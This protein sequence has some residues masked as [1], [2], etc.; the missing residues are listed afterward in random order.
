MRCLGVCV[1]VC[2]LVAAATAGRTQEPNEN[3]CHEQPNTAAINA[4]LAQVYADI[5]V[6]LNEAYRAGL[7]KIEGSGLQ[8][9]LMKDWRRAFQEA[10]RKWIAFREADCGPP[11]AYEWTSGSAAGAMQLGCKIERTRERLSALQRRYA[12]RG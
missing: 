8:P 1:V 3:K 7:K 5:D 9:N 6:A 4:C 2:A 11:V 10:Q 12:G